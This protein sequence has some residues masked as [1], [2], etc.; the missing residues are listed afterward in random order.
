MKLKITN[1]MKVGIRFEKDHIVFKEDLSQESLVE[2]LNIVDFCA[3]NKE[4]IKKL[5]KLKGIEIKRY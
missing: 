1:D 2:F 3:E 5:K 4:A